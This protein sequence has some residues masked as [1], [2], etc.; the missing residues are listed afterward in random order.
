LRDQSFILSR[1]ILREGHYLK[2]ANKENFMRLPLLL[3]RRHTRSDRRGFYRPALLVQNPTATLFK[4][5][6]GKSN[7]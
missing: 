2:S 3:F 4:Q 6:L 1:G 5:Q 7:V